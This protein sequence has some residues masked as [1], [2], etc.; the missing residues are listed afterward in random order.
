MNTTTNL[1]PVMLPAE[2]KKK[3]QTPEI[4]VLELERHAMLLAGSLRAT[5]SG[6]GEAEEYDW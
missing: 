5:R 1:V 6:Y 3:Y 4:Q 2:T